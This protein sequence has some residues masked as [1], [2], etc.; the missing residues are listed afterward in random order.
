MVDALLDLAHGQVGSKL[1]KHFHINP[2]AGAPGADLVKAVVVV[3][4]LDHVAHDPKLQ[5]L[6]ECAVK[7]VANRG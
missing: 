5:G 2:G 7:K 1:K 6:F 4:V 3:E